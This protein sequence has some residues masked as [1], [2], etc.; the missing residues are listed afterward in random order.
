[1][2]SRGNEGESD[3]QGSVRRY[4]ELGGYGFRGYHVEESPKPQCPMQYGTAGPLKSAWLL[5]ALWPLPLAAGPTQDGFFLGQ[6][7]VVPALQR[8]LAGGRKKPAV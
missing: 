3:S 5:S 2:S 8:P 1:M 6:G 7:R 4:G